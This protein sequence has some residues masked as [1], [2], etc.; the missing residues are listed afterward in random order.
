MTLAS[1]DDNHLG[2]DVAIAFAESELQTSPGGGLRIRRGGNFEALA[3]RNPHL[4]VLARRGSATVSF[5]EVP[6][7]AADLF[8]A[9]RGVL[10][11]GEFRVPGLGSPLGDASIEM[12]SS[13]MGS[14]WIA[15]GG[16]DP[17]NIS[18]ATA[19]LFFLGEFV[20]VFVIFIAAGAGAMLLSLPLV[21]RAVRPV[22]AAAAVLQPDKPA[23]LS[24]QDSP[25]ELLPLVRSFNAALDRAADELTRRRRFIADV[26]H[27]LR[28]PLALTHL[29]VE[30]LP[31]V[32]GKSDLQRAVARLSQLV[33]QMLDVERLSLA[34]QRRERIDLVALARET[35]AEMVPLALAAGYDLA[36]VAP[37]SPVIVAGDEHALSRSISN[38]IGNAVAHGGGKGQIVVT[39]TE[40]RTLTVADEGPGVPAKIRA[41]VFEPFCR[42][43]RDRDG[44]GLGLHLVREIM[45]AHGGDAALIAEGPG[46]TFRLEFPTPA[47]QVTQS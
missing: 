14:L 1:G 10:S 2:P 4:W 19:M 6:P 27:E 11:M 3:Q 42:H 24:E 33:S 18:V 37:G 26:A 45:R 20:I 22:V 32:S 34:T 12:R 17:S 29:R 36:L 7:A 23:R 9:Q 15:A 40:W 43:R 5:G 35:T 31:E 38:L 8:T 25:R 47:N 16:T 28:T 41:T 21:G 30:G 44:C 13:D 39:V 46:A